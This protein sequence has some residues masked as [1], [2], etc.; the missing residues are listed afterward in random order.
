MTASRL[1]A[2]SFDTVTQQSPTFHEVR[3]SPFKVIDTKVRT[4]ADVSHAEA[5]AIRRI[6]YVAPEAFEV[7]IA[8]RN[9]ERLVLTYRPFNTAN[10]VAVVSVS[11]H[12]ALTA[13]LFSGRHEPTE[14]TEAVDGFHEGLSYLAIRFDHERRALPFKHLP[15]LRPALFIV[16]IDNFPHPEL[17][18]TLHVFA[19]AFM[20]AFLKPHT[21]RRP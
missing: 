13:G 16:D 12:H 15:R 19:R 17:Q 3:L 14:D 4:I 2:F 11:G 1:A 21:R 9:I 18:P 5:N 6:L 10:G 7:E 20:V 8:F